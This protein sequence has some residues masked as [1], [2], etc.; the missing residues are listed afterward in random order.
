MAVRSKAYVCSRSIAGIEG[1]NPAAGM[2][3]R[4]LCLLCVE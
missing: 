1:S 3:V 2:N 4:L